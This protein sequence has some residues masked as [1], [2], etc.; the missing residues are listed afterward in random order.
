MRLETVLWKGFMTMA[1]PMND[2]TRLYVEMFQRVICG[3]EKPTGHEGGEF[4]ERFNSTITS[5]Y[6]RQSVVMAG[7]HDL[8]RRTKP[9][10]NTLTMFAEIGDIVSTTEVRR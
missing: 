10:G 2:R 3:Y 6:C 9:D 4:Y 1:L 5:C 8:Y 7:V